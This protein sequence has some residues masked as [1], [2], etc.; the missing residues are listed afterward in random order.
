[1]KT[2]KDEYDK[3]VEAYKEITKYELKI[4]IKLIKTYLLIMAIIATIIASIFYFTY[5][6]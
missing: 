2:D 3:M 1:M 4:R 5:Y 6:Y